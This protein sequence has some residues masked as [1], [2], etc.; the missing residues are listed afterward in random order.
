MS[1][2]Y[3]DE[4]LNF[5]NIFSKINIV[6]L[7]HLCYTTDCRHNTLKGQIVSFPVFST[8]APGTSATDCN[9]GLSSAR[10]PECGETV[11]ADWWFRAAWHATRQVVE[12]NTVLVKTCFAKP[13]RI[14]S[15]AGDTGLPVQGV[16]GPLGGA[17]GPAP[18]VLHRQRGHDR[19]ERGR[20]NEAREHGTSSV[21]RLFVREVARSWI[22]SRNFLNKDFY[23]LRI[24]LNQKVRRGTPQSSKNCEFLKSLVSRAHIS[25]LFSRS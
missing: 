12:S 2:L 3:F 24:S 20:E 23:F 6:G 9:G 18:E 13:T 21:T 17:G 4:L 11:L 7:Y 25:P 14:C 10:I 1:R 16:R 19:V 5:F 15:R 8:L 22:K